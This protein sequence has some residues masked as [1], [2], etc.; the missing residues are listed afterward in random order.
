MLTV[1]LLA[2]LVQAKPALE[3]PAE[4]VH[5]VAESRITY[6]SSTQSATC[7]QWIAENMFYEKRGSR[8]VISRN[9]RGVRWAIDTQTRVYSETSLVSPNQPAAA[10]TA[11]EDI[12][13]A[14]FDYEP[15]F[16]WT[17]SKPGK[18][19]TI[20]G[21]ACTLTSATGTA[22]FAEAV[23]GLWLCRSEAPSVERKA[24]GRILEMVRFRYQDPVTFGMELL[25]KQPEMVLMG[26]EA[27]IDPPIAP[28]MVHEVKVLTFEKSLPPPGIFDLPAGLQK[29]VR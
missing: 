22:A 29:I 25:S 13:T 6:M 10:G 16:A 3:Q 9:D 24:N 14:G 7:E 12:H 11:P 27:T 2:L 20:N 1:L 19:A 4:A 15:A 21:R 28:R 8:V 17:V 18:T 23:L 26:L 5:I